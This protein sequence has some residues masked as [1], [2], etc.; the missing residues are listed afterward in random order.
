[1]M[2]KMILLLLCLFLLGKSDAA[3]QFTNGQDAASV[4]GQNNFT[5]SIETMTAGG[6]N[7]PVD[8]VV[9]LVSGKVFVSDSDNNRV[10]RFSTA[11]AFATGASAEAVLG[12]SG[13]NLKASA[14]TQNGMYQPHGLA[15]DGS[16][17]LFVSDSKNN[18]VLRFANAASLANGANAAS[19]L[20][21]SN[22]TNDTK[23]TT[24]NGMDDP[25]G[26]AID[27]SGNLYVV[28]SKNN[29]VLR[30][31][32]AASLPNG[33]NATRVLGQSGFTNSTK[34]T[35]QNGL[36]TPNDVAVG[37]GVLYVADTKNNR[38]LVFLNAA[39]LASGANASS[40]LG[41][42]NFTNNG[43]STSQ[44]RMDENLGVGTDD[45]GNLYVGDSK[46][47]R[48]LIFANAASLPN[49]ANAIR[50]L[51]QFDFDENDDETSRN[52][53]K[54]PCSVSVISATG[55]VFVVDNEN[56]RV[57]RFET[58]GGVPLPV[59]LTDF[60]FRKVDVG[61]ELVW[62]TATEKNNAGFTV[63]RN[64]ETGS[65]AS[66]TDRKEWSALGFV[67]GNGTTT[68]SKS[69]SFIDRT[70][71]G[72]VSYRLKQVDFDGAFEYSPIVEAEVASPKVFTLEQNYPNPFNPSTVISYQ[73]PVSSEVSLKIYDVLGRELQT[74]VNTRQDAGRYQAQFNAASL[75]SGVYFY[76]LSVNGATNGAQ[77][78]VQ[79][80][81]MMLVK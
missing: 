69:Y 59:E 3:G 37:G 42:S 49:G 10:L 80:K 65:S 74:L 26:L 76:R 25:I 28:D 43:G 36:D 63:E 39:S 38:V 31:A 47:N 24:Q 4:M 12:Q 61:I 19:V 72:K 35:S 79:T 6:M 41:Q 15:I 57:L 7:L 78:F 50:V 67:K 33:A 1:M 16:G 22:F 68:E 23:A 70:A 77:N 81:K 55:Q 48:V 14:T 60:G 20:G 51:G 54:T 64:T 30:F 34:A 75:S 17:N 73:L 18:R 32:N 29:R 53:M 27:A 13:F 46:N 9:D 44:N 21:Q 45:A 2:K 56:S 40:V 5:T 52:G 11:G 62:T 71:S 66:L 58:S 8:V